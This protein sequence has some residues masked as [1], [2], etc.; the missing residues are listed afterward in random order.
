MFASTKKNMSKIKEKIY[1]GI[2]VSKLYLDAACGNQ[3]KRFDFTNKGLNDLLQWCLDNTADME[4]HFISEPSGAYEIPLAEFLSEQDIPWSRP[5]ALRVRQFAR[6]SGVLAETDRLDAKILVAYGEKFSP[7]PQHLEASEVRELREL[8]KRRQQ[9]MQLMV[10]EKVTLESVQNGFCR[11]EINNSIRRFER[12]IARI[13]ERID[14]HLSKEKQLEQKV[15]IIQQLKGVGLQSALALVAYLPELGY[16]NRREIASLGGLAPVTRESGMWKGVSK[17]GPGRV[18][19]RRA[20]YMAALSAC[21]FNPQMKELYDR[22]KA[23]GKPSKVAL[24][25]V[26]R[27]LP[28][29]LNTLMKASFP[30]PSKS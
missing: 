7:N 1:I 14:A 16:V 28:T 26:A 5:N 13:D 21:R 12:D 15:K 25:A 18:Q 4:L 24:C 17:L 11:K 9:V 29:A 19:V 20:L 6:A 2:D 27:R 23:N 22:M 3:T 8:M 30:Q 10:Q